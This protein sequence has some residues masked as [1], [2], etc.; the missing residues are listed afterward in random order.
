[1]GGI[2]ATRYALHQRAVRVGSSGRRPEDGGLS[3]AEGVKSDR[4]REIGYLMPEG[5]LNLKAAGPHNF[6]ERR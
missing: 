4:L 3:E 5:Q 2:P 1:M 6:A